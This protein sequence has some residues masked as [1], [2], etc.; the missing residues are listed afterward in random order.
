MGG[1]PFGY[2][3]IAALEM[4]IRAKSAKRESYEEQ[5][6]RLQKTKDTH[7]NKADEIQRS[8]NNLTLSSGQLSSRQE[9]L[10][11]VAT[12]NRNAT[13]RLLKIKHSLV[14]TQNNLADINA[15]AQIAFEPSFSPS[16]CQNILRIVLL[17]PN[18]TDSNRQEDELQRIVIANDICMIME[19]L[20]Q[21]LLTEDD[22]LDYG[23]EEK[24]LGVLLKE[25]QAFLRS[26]L[27][28]F[29]QN[30]SGNA[31]AVL[32][33]C[34]YKQENWLALKRSIMGKV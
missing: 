2:V 30:V 34:R 29:E 18:V 19:K 25:A 28:V 1:I 24:S 12:S 4:D 9:L 32:D 20:P 15:S 3:G 27:M 5:L 17:M 33:R 6:I 21:R 23:S 10:Q 7:R 11:R 14:G 16:Y 26:R 22:P 8:I 31:E 13:D